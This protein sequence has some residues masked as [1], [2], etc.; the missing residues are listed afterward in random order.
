MIGWNIGRHNHAKM[1]NRY[2]IFLS[3]LLAVDLFQTQQFLT[4][5]NGTTAML[6]MLHKNHIF[7]EWSRDTNVLEHWERKVKVPLQLI[8]A[9][10]LNH[11]AF[12]SS[13]LFL[14]LTW[15][16]RY[17]PQI[18][19]FIATNISFQ[20]KTC[21]LNRF[22]YK[23]PCIFIWLCMLKLSRTP[24]H[25]QQGVRKLFCIYISKRQIECWALAIYLQCFNKKVE[26]GWQK[27][28]KTIEKRWKEEKNTRIDK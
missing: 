26:R 3:L 1:F 11:F 4:N 22:F 28:T 25:R 7:Y 10:H 8:M 13:F 14:F 6:W 12:I 24:S 17:F 27:A 21:L 20:R 16:W 19:Y 18:S 2:W 23:F 5:V 15:R 9:N